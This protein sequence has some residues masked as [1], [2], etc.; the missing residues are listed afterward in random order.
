MLGD[1]ERPTQLRPI[2]T[3]VRVRNLTDHLGRHTRFHLAPVEGPRLDRLGV[4][5]EVDRRP[6]DEGFMGQAGVDDLSRHR[7]RQRDISAHVEPHP[8]VGE[9]C[10]RR[11]PRIHD[12]QPGAAAHSRQHMMEEDGMRFAGIRAP[13]HD[14]VGFFDL[15]VRRRSTADSEHCRQTDDAGSVSS[16]IAR[17]DVVRADHRPR[18]LLRQ[19]V[20]LV[21]CLRATEHA[22]R[23]RPFGLYRSAKPGHRTVE[24]FVPCRLAQHAA[25]SHQR[26]G[27]P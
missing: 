6:V 7:V 26:L 25:L 24:C 3:R 10:G 22:D 15:F 13:Q 21:G 12:E 2:G 5:V 4:D 8:Y 11:A 23:V 19:V 9:L 18:E 27:Q 16:S 20:H 14:H 1:A 17:I